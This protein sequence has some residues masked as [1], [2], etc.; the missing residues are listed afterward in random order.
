[1]NFVKK[2]LAIEEKSGFLLAASALLAIVLKNSFFESHYDLWV[3]FSF[4]F[5]L[6]NMHFKSPLIFWVNDFLM[7]FFFFLIGLELKREFLEGH[8]REPKNIALPA[9][10]ALGGLIVPAVLYCLF[11]RNDP[12][13]LKGW[14]IPI[15]TDI[16]F[17][18]GILSL[19]GNRVPKALKICL[20][21]LA[22]FD[23]IASIVVIALF[24]TETISFF[25]CGVS[26]FFMVSL[27]FL[28]RMHFNTI[29]AYGWVGILLWIGILKSGIHPTLS[30]IILGLAIPLRENNKKISLLKKTEHQLHPWVSWVV[31]PV[32][33]FFN[34]GI[35]MKGLSLALFLHPVSLG[36]ALGL[37]V[38]KPVGVMLFSWIAVRFGFCTLPSKISWIEFY[39]MALLTGVGF[40]MS[41]FIG[42]LSFSEPEYQN[43]MKL[44]VLTG[45]V[46]SGIL[47]YSVLRAVLGIQKREVVL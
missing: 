1:M 31:L 40:T 43:I 26:V 32:F 17:A 39:G 5:T 33:A 21:S 22:I 28:N 27:F 10:A 24:Y 15:A 36:I 16:A 12:N 46:L 29:W 42:A 38:G 13:A 45:S 37:W 19:L 47:G 35:S 41:L 11:A 4:D 3:N 23:D 6:L 34:S 7:S 44:G 20:L 18:V 9:I 25:W 14:A 30:G 8:L 2:F